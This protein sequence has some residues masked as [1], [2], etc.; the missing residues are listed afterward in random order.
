ML[1]NK[2]GIS[3][4]MN[5]IIGKNLKIP[6]PTSIVIGD[7]VVIGDN[8]TLYQNVTLGKKKGNIDS[9]RDYP[10][11]GNNVTIFA[12]AQIIGNVLI[13][14]GAVIG[15][16]SVVLE[17]VEENGVYAGIPAKKLNK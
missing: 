11:I 17:D 12:G 2:Y 6:H 13:G 14:D 5:S 3:V 9:T 1:I 16:N 8:V 10:I 4:G 7:G 15:A